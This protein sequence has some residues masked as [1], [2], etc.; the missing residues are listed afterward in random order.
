VPEVRFRWNP[1]LVDLRREVCP[2]ARWEKNKRRWFMNDTEAATFL[3]AAHAR[4]DLAKSRAE[5]DVDDVRWV[6]GFVLGA[7]YRESSA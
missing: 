4:L 6:V 3:R 7:P 2:A 1:L 5:I